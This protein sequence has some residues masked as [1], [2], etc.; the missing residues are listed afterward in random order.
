[1]NDKQK[2]MIIAG[3][4]IVIGM[5]EALLYYNLGKNAESDK[6]KFGIPKGAELA[7]SLAV[8]LV[9]STLTALLSN[10][11]EN[12]LGNKVASAKLQLAQA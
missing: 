2:F 5:A 10:Q 12:A 8:V 6:F 11:I 9:T 1:M 7:K 3:A 4:G